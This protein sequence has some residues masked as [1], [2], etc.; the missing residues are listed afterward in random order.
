MDL[1]PTAAR[2]L[3]E[4]ME[5]TLIVHKLR[6][7]NQHRRT[8]CCTNLIESALSFNGAAAA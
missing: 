6:V 2:N 8:L 3:E 7:Q 4:G 1:N 5:E